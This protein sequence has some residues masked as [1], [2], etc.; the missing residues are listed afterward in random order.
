[1]RKV[2]T[3]VIFFIFLLIGL[4]AVESSTMV[5]AQS[6]SEITTSWLN[7][8]L[9]S[10]KPNS[11]YPLIFSMIDPGLS[12]DN[13]F[14]SYMTQPV[15]NSE[16]DMLLG[17]GAQSI[18]IEI[19]YDAWLE[20]DTQ[21]IA[22]LDHYI[23]GMQSNG[24]QV[25]IA[26][27]GAGLYYSN[28]LTWAQF[29]VAWIQRVQT[30]AERYH[31][32]YYIVIKEPGFYVPQISDASTNTQFQN[33]SDWGNLTLALVNAVKQVSP[34]TK[35]GF[36]VPAN[37]YHQQSYLQADILSAV[38]H[39]P[40]LDFI[41]FDIYNING[42]EDTLRFLTQIGS[43]GKPVWSAEAWSTEGTGVFNSS[44]ASLDAE[45][46]Q[47]V[48]DFA[49]H[50]H[51]QVLAPFYTDAFASYQQPPTNTANLLSYYQGRTPVFTAFQNIIAQNKG[52]S[53]SSTTATIFTS[54]ASSSNNTVST[55]STSTPSTV[56]TT[57]TS[58][59]PGPK[60]SRGEELLIAFAI[61]FIVIAIVAMYFGVRKNQ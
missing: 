44:R 20:N 56:S 60:L 16:L 5:S 37:L 11:T 48:Y 25:V 19:G 1:M 33:V 58:S 43:N 51:A 59:I 57:P 29:K 27:A 35:V 54:P 6:S 39:I 55:Q 13:P 21:G 61:I 22:T 9:T 23:N 53:T 15:L 49:L 52:V 14:Q 46:A 17:T 31:P 18:R 50:I 32:A 8:Q 42:F 26:D 34:N 24:T 41:G 4:T 2:P 7:Q 47:V 30:I 40:Q 28:P 38:I 12:H 10:W 3:H 36:T 45:W